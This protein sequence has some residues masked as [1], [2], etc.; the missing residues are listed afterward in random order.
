MT[1]SACGVA[2]IPHDP[3]HPL[4]AFNQFTLPDS[5]LGGGVSLAIGSLSQHKKASLIQGRF[6]LSSFH[7]IT[8]TVSAR[9]QPMG[10]DIQM[11]VTPRAGMADRT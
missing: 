7:K 6:L 3:V 5:T 1:T 11:P 2:G 10:I 9:N 4:L 8:P